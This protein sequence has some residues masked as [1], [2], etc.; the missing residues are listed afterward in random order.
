MPI[1]RSPTNKSASSPF[2]DLALERGHS[3]DRALFLVAYRHL[4]GE[5][6]RQADA[7]L[8]AIEPPLR[9]NHAVLP[10]DQEEIASLEKF[11]RDEGE[12]VR[13]LG[14]DRGT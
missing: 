12:R 5:R 8:F 7:P 6:D 11:E 4:A 1:A 13:P 9:K 2:N 3:Y 10:A 14:A